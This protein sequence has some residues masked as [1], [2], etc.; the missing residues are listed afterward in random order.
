MAE[1]ELGLELDS[2]QVKVGDG[3][4]TWNQLPYIFFN[5]GD[6]GGGTVDPNVL[7]RG[8]N[9]SELFNDAEYI[10]IGDEIDNVTVNGAM[11]NGDVAF[12]YHRN[13]HGVLFNF[14]SSSFRFYDYHAI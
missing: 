13:S 11:F 7:K 1:G 4:R 10:S 9:V 12:N 14:N 3:V 5:D 8:D 6:G 2:N